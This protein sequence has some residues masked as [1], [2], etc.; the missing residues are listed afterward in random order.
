MRCYTAVDGSSDENGYL[1]GQVASC[2]GGEQASPLSDQPVRR[3]HDDF[4]SLHPRVQPQSTQSGMAVS[5][6]SDALIETVA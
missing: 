1:P 2:K 5:N 4:V 3:T 6:T